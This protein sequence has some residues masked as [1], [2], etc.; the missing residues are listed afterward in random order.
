L[1]RGQAWLKKVRE[2]E[3]AERGRAGCSS[4]KEERGEEKEDRIKGKD[5]HVDF[6]KINKFN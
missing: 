1:S 6:D 5:E 4:K 2:R 3:A